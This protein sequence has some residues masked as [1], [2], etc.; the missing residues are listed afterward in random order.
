M[1]PCNC[2]DETAPTRRRFRPFAVLFQGLLAYVLLVLAGGTL[3]NVNHPVA[4]EAGRLIQTVAFVEPA[5]D[6]AD[7][8][9]FDSLAGGL[10]VVAAG[11]P[12]H[13]QSSATQSAA[14]AA[15]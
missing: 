10:R 11:I 1:C 2:C 5:I 12:L 3:K 6:W 14:R 9:G 15:F 4:I 13:G 7:R 8:R